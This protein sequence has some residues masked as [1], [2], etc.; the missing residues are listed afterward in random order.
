VPAALT[1]KRDRGRRPATW[2]VWS[3]LVLVAALLVLGAV[4]F[5]LANEALAATK[6]A[7]LV[8]SVVPPLAFVVVGAVIVTRRPGTTIGWL[9]CPSAWDKAW[10]PSA[11]K[12]RPPSLPPTRV[13]FPAGWCCTNWG[14]WPGSCPG[15]P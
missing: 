12:G 4:P 1:P 8:A 14:A 6:K 15:Y 5:T 3:L 9:C 10:R 7:E 11:A 2:L 13:G